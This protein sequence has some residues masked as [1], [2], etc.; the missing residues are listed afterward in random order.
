VNGAGFGV[1]PTSNTGN[2]LE[3][4]F[5]WVKPGGE[6]DG[7]SDSTATRYDSFCGLADG[8]SSNYFQIY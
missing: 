5:V 6:S 7:T 8:K 2:P 3:D 1:R 4:A